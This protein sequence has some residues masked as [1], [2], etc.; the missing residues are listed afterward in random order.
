MHRRDLLRFG[1][2]AAALAIARRARA[3]MAAP[4]RPMAQIFSGV[5]AGGAQ[6]P[7][8]VLD[9]RPDGSRD[10]VKLEADLGAHAAHVF[11]IDNANQRFVAWAMILPFRKGQWPYLVF[12]DV[13]R[14][15]SSVGE[16][17]TQHSATFELDAALAKTIASGF[18]VVPAVRMPL[19]GGVTYAWSNPTKTRIRLRIDNKGNGALRTLGSAGDRDHRFSFRVRKDGREIAIKEVMVIDESAAIIALKAKDHVDLEVD[20]RAWIDKPGVYDVDCAFDGQLFPDNVSMGAWPEHAAETW[21]IHAAGAL[22]V[23]VP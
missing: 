19:D 16:D 9:L 23:I 17:D 2:G 18:G 14:A 22:R 6:V 11:S 20:L 1:A 12:G 10:F 13:V 7:G 21:D 4:E 8:S 3:D 15:A 5:S